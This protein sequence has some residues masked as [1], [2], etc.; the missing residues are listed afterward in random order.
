[1]IPPGLEYH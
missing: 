1:M